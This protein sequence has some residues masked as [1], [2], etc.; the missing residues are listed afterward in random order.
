MT[1]QFILHSS[2]LRSSVELFH[3]AGRDAASLRMSGDVRA[4][5]RQRALAPGDGGVWNTF[6]I[7]SR[8]TGGASPFGT[9]S[10]AVSGLRAAFFGVPAR[11]DGRTV[12]TLH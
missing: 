4:P 1:G 6:G 3:A 5:V 2:G 9:I 10:D 7:G 8:V 12:T 11:V